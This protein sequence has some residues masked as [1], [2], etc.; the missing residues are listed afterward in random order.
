MEGSG[1]VNVFGGIELRIEDDDDDRLHPLTSARFTIVDRGTS[2]FSS[3]QLIMSCS[4]PS[5]VSCN[6]IHGGW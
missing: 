1:P 5:T 4:E 2:D 3:V 6:Y